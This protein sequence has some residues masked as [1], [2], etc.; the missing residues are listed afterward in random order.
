[1]AG[2]PSAEQFV[3]LTIRA[4]GKAFS[5]T[6]SGPNAFGRAISELKTRTMDFVLSGYLSTLEKYL[7]ELMFFI[8]DYMAEVVKNR[9]VPYGVTSSQVHVV[10]GSLIS[11]IENQST[12]SVR[13]LARSVQAK[14]ILGIAEG[15]TRY[16]RSSSI[17]GSG[18]RE[19]NTGEPVSGYGVRLAKRMEAEVGLENVMNQ[20]MAALMP[21]GA[22]SKWM[23]SAAVSSLIAR[24]RELQA[25]NMQKIETAAAARI[26]DAKRGRTSRR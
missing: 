18:V 2:S 3:R 8:G 10:T 7:G 12:R 4:T 26:A 19:R 23:G 25:I 21:T 6:Y 24:T 1:M 16:E 9:M 17:S 22:V 5:G 15:A 20:E 14:I 13:A 11:S